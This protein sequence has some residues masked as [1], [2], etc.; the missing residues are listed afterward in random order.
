M[1]QTIENA[2]DTIGLPWLEWPNPEFLPAALVG[3]QMQAE[4][5][6]LILFAGEGEE[7]IGL[8]T[9]QAIADLG[10]HVIFP[11]EFVSRLPIDLRAQV[12]NARIQAARDHEVVA[13][14]ENGRFSAFI[15]SNRE[16]LTYRETAELSWETLTAV[17]GDSLTIERATVGGGSGMNLQLMTQLERPITR[18]L[19]DALSAGIQVRQ[20][21]GHSPEISLYIK[22]LVC[23]NGM[24]ANRTEFSWARRAESSR[25]HQQLWLRDGI[26]A[27]LTNFQQIVD[28]SR[29]MAQTAVEGDPEEALLERARA[30]GVPRRHF[31]TLREAWR[32]EE[33][34]SEWGMVNA[35]T[36]MATHTALPGDLGRRLQDAAGSWATNFDIVDCR[37]PRPVA[38]R[39]GAHII[40]GTD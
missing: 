30:M 24:T 21:Y 22:R 19:G 26:A 2:N 11:N 29:T 4:G 12:I 39:V 18:R 32:V 5:N 27:A 37:L 23:L 3:L 40:S 25:E 16:M 33:D 13:V 35:I 17:V 15:P 36:R 10:G 28:R 7:R 38:E 9:D 34:R 31:G 14:R 8:A 1:P 20:D 6:D